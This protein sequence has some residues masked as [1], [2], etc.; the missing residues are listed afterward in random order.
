MDTS[1]SS[2]ADQARPTAGRKAPGIMLSVRTAHGNP[3]PSTNGGGDQTSSRES[4]H[5]DNHASACVAHTSTKAPAACC[6]RPHTPDRSSEAAEGGWGIWRPTLRAGTTTLDVSACPV[7]ES[8][9]EGRNQNLGGGVCCRVEAGAAPNR[10]PHRVVLGQLHHRRELAPAP[11]PTQPS[12]QQSGPQSALTP[13]ACA[14]FSVRSELLDCCEPC[15]P[16][17]AIGRGVTCG[18]AGR[19]PRMELQVERQTT[20][21]TRSA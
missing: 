16:F 12:H 19:T 3:K 13:R 4:A 7:S 14:V 6:P 11:A 15:Q 2:S 1:W 8:A 5:H 21:L 18:A 20:E 10:L 9:Q 17:G